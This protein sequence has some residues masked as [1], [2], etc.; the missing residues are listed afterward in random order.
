MPTPSI[1]RCFTALVLT[2]VFPAMTW[3]DLESYVKAHDDSYG[4]KVIRE[5][6]LP[7][8]PLDR[9]RHDGARDSR[10]ASLIGSERLDL[11]YREV[12]AGRTG[13][14]GCDQDAD[15]YH[16]DNSTDHELSR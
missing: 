10:V 15:H 7:G 6:E 2:F 14:A 12:I 4:W 13:E 9:I 11:G 16:N 3:A 1:R 8:V 5:M